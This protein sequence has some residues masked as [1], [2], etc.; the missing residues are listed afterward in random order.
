MHQ[1]YTKKQAFD[2]IRALDIDDTIKRRLELYFAPPVPAVA[3]TALDWLGRLAADNKD[4]RA[5]IRYIH[6]ANGVAVATNGHVIGWQDT[7]LVDGYYCPKTKQPVT[8]NQ[9]YPDTVNLLQQYRDTPTKA[10]V[11]S[12]DMVHRVVN[13]ELTVAH[14][15]ADIS[16]QCNLEYLQ[17]A[18]NRESAMLTLK[19]R[20][21]FGK[22]SHGDF[23]IMNTRV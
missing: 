18:T 5:R 7:D 2:A 15:P 13:T 19:E 11:L 14:H 23:L 22:C 12:S 21:I 20:C 4:I 9:D 17:K 1:R 6:V 10:T 16:L 3:K 8:V